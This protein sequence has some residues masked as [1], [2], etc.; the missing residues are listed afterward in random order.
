MYI[1]IALAIAVLVGI[2]ISLCISI[3]HDEPGASVIYVMVCAFVSTTGL[4]IAY[5]L[6][7]HVI[8]KTQ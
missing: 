4:Y 8:N 7:D 3:Y 2:E 6:I 5:N 1:I